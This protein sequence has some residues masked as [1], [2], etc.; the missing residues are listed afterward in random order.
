MGDRYTRQ[1][2]LGYIFCGYW[3]QCK[4]KE[5]LGGGIKGERSGGTEEKKE[6]NWQHKFVILTVYNSLLPQ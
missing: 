2:G 1:R 5:L 3:E 4:S 6:E